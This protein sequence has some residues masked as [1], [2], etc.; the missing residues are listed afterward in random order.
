M[1]YKCLKDSENKKYIIPTQEWLEPL[2]KFI[3]DDINTDGL[4]MLTRLN[5]KH[6]VIV[7][8]TRNNEEK[9]KL[10]KYANVKLFGLTNFMLTFCSFNCLESTVNIDA[11]YNNVKGYC[12]PTSDINE[13]IFIEIMYQ[14]PSSLQKYIG[15]LNKTRVEDICKQLI[16][17]QTQTF[18]NYGFLH[19][20]L[21][22]GNILRSKSLKK[23]K[24][25][26]I[27][28]V[29]P[30]NIYGYDEKIY[31]IETNI[32]VVISDYGKSVFFDNS[33][34]KFTITK[35]HLLILNLIKVLIECSKL[36]NDQNE[37][38]K[39]KKI[40]D[41]KQLDIEKHNSV[42][43]RILSSYNKGSRDL[44]LY[45]IDVLNNAFRYVDK[46][47]I[48]YFGTYLFNVYV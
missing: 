34:P 4:L 28:Y 37:K 26:K 12:K 46:V 43:L 10:L 33:Y 27:S 9:Y 45:K 3:T 29:F 32:E 48:E 19:M 7:K 17:A 6:E 21:H 35:E 1:S 20:D 5:K 47:W 15:L 23:G 8:I 14:Y 39:F 30:R 25:K 16:Y 13:K 22:L 44:E 40:I 24:E 11:N 31:E 38:N 36:L 42:E 41:D 18:N 2:N